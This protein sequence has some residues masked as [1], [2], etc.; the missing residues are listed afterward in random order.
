MI[1]QNGDSIVSD[2]KIVLDK[3]GK[4]S[5]SVEGTSLLRFLADVYGHTTIDQLE[6]KERTAT[7]AEVY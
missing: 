5:F 7:A 4:Y 3:N 6:E 1:E 2:F